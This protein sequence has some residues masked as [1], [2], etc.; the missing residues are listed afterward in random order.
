M[1][2]SLVNGSHSTLI[3]S[4]VGVPQGPILGCVLLKVFVNDLEEKME[5]AVFK[6]ADHTKNQGKCVEGMVEIF[7][8]LLATAARFRMM[9]LQGEEFVCLKSIILLNSGVYTFLSS[10]LKS[11]EERDYIHRVLDKITDTLIHLMAKS[12]LSLQ[13]QH[14]RL[15]QLLLILSHIRHMS[16][17]GMEHLYNMKCK[18]VV[19][20]YDL[21][22]EMLDAHRLH[23]PAARSAA[24][25]EEENRSQLTSASASSHS[26]QSFY[27]NS[28]E[29]D[30]MQNTI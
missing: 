27:I 10:T 7:D 5:S 16:N 30:N 28:K 2:R 20:L 1:T 8:M 23:A 14:R 6:P 29:E 11:L 9:N 25:M 12:G 26:L 13:Q 18:N 15:A 17:K 24:P 3:L 21:L 22:L 19:P 4:T